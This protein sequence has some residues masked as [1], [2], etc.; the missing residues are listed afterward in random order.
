MRQYWQL[1]SSF[2]LSAIRW[3]YRLLGIVR[4]GEAKYH[5]ERLDS[6]KE[7]RGKSGKRFNLHSWAVLSKFLES[8]SIPT[9]SPVIFGERIH[10]RRSIS[11]RARISSCQTWLFRWDWQSTVFRIAI[12][13][14]VNYHILC[15][16]RENGVVRIPVQLLYKLRAARLKV[17]HTLI[18]CKMSRLTL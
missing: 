1:S 10:L 8:P 14:Y 7:M 16:R 11:I 9:T 18:M 5:R 12:V 17:S 6:R 13:V 4:K 2:Y 15:M 3:E